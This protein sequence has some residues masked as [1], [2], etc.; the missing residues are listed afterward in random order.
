MIEL[1]SVS[2]GF[3]LSYFVEHPN[4][5]KSIRELFLRIAQAIVKLCAYCWHRVCKKNTIEQ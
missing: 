4:S 5:R 2:I 3:I 1:I